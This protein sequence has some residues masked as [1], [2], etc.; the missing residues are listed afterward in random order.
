MSDQKLKSATKYIVER[1][2]QQAPKD[3]QA[4]RDA[5]KHPGQILVLNGY[6]QA[7]ILHKYF[8]VTLKESEI[9]E[10]MALIDTFLKSKQARQIS[11]LNKEA[12]P[13]R[14]LEVQALLKR[15]EVQKGDKAYL[16]RNF[17]SAKTQKFKAKNPDD[18]SQIQARYV[19][20]LASRRGKP[21]I[22]PSDLSSKQDIGHGDRGA[23]ASQF[24]VDR[25]IA[26]AVSKFNLNVSQAQQLKSIATRQREKHKLKINVAHEQ[27]FESSGKFK[28]DYSFVLS[29]QDKTINALDKD[30]EVAA[31]RGSIEEY[32]LLEAETSTLFK[33]ALAEITLYNLAG[34]KRRNKKV[35]G[36]RS[37]KIHEKNNVNESVDREVEINTG[38]VV[39]RGLATKGVT[40]NR[41]KRGGKT[42]NNVASQPLQLIGLI[43]KE[44]PRTVLKNMGAPRLKNLTGTF[45]RSVEVTDIVQTAKGFPSI[46]YTYDRQPYGVFEDGGGAAPW[47]NG[48]RDPRKLI[49]RSIREIA[50]QFAI[51]RFYTRRQ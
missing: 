5:Q 33:D 44:L 34:K 9:T 1:A 46:G 11:D 10:M 27:I 50:A 42:V 48:H 20:G 49:D 22:N 39:Q 25:A 2:T 36:K 18:V 24:G 7:S 32:N 19:N 28:K 30:K 43:N 26:E 40:K 45:A 21:D 6:H 37:K 14:V 35:T 4:R 12:G 16:I 38:Y 29:Y 51:G 31:L 8:G 23:S 15:S 41:S 3:S 13:D 17:E 47:A